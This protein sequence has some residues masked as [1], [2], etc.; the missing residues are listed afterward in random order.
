MDDTCSDSCSICTGENLKFFLPVSK[1][2]LIEFIQLEDGLRSLATADALINLVCKNEQWTDK[3]FNMKVHG[4]RKYQ[5][6]AVFLQ[7][8]A[9]Q[10]ILAVTN[11]K[12]LR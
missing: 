10:M 1:S 5:V 9:A 3:I 12:K 7:L 6:E 4:T 2:G 8:I 11:E